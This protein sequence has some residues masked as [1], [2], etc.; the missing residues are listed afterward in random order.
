MLRHGGGGVNPMPALQ[1]DYQRKLKSFSWGHAA[2]LAAAMAT[3]IATAIY[4]RELRAKA[5]DW[6]V[7]AER[8]ERVS[9]PRG[10]PDG[11]AAADL[12]L[13][14]KQANDVARQLTLPWERLFQ[15]LESVSGKD[16]SLLGL[17]PNTERKVVK[18]RGEAKNMA[19]LLDYIKRLEQCGAFG[20]VFLQNHMVQQQDPDQPVRFALL[21]DWDGKS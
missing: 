8:M 20:T 1:L 3:V 7:K 16:V 17:E 13:E 10:G 11:A 14:L 18:I 12:A 5:D 19:V 6:D 15:A 21:A 4:Y 2:L 9:R